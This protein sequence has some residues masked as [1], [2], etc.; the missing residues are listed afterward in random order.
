MDLIKLLNQNYYFLVPALWV[1]G[2]ALK[3]TPRVPDWSIIWYL[4]G[5]SLVLAWIAFGFNVDAI[6][7]GILAAGA[8]V[9]GH[10][11]LKQTMES[12]DSRKK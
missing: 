3:K 7:N 11:T 1:I 8:A 6:L 12:L 5:I 4:F 10:Q 9:F 2:Y